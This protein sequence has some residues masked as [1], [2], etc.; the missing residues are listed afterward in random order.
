MTI[1][2]LPKLS[3]NEMETLFKQSKKRSRN[4]MLFTLLWAAFCIWQCLTTTNL[5]LKKYLFI[6]FCIALGLWFVIIVGQLLILKFISFKLSESKESIIGKF[7]IEE[8]RLLVDEVFK[9]SLTNEKP[10]LY[11]LNLEVVNASAINIYLLNFIKPANAV[12][13]T[14]KSFNCL[15]REEIKAMLLHEMGHFNK[16]MYDESKILNIGLYLFFIMPF[17]FTILIS[18]FLL[19]VGFIIVAIVTIVLISEKVRNSKNYDKHVLE[20]LCD[21]YAAE[22][23]GLLTT[24][25]MLIT[26]AKENIV[27]EEKEKNK[28][29]KKIFLPVKRFMVDWSAFDTHIVNGKIEMEEYDKL[30]ETLAKV[31][32]PQLV[33]NSVVDHNSR[34]HPS[35]TNRLIFLHRNLKT[36]V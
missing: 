4:F 2:D 22:K 12:Y 33:D 3:K 1:H 20:Y 10:G 14:K 21:L 28:I 25:N 18:G 32:N 30:I 24:I 15:T 11:I 26:L 8:I 23:E 7:T 34:S 9:V 36:K 29:L 19:K 27:S 35:L 13:I 5:V 17:A 6:F 31:E 16:Y